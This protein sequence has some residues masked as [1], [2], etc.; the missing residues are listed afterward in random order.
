MEM[1]KRI[2]LERRGRPENEVSPCFIT[3][4][5]LE[6]DKFFELDRADERARPPSA[7]V[8]WA[9]ARASISTYMLLAVVHTVCHCL[10]LSNWACFVVEG[11]FFV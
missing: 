8:S 6:I 7:L 10:A 5:D 3:S 11:I 2:E 9:L 4:S 1:S